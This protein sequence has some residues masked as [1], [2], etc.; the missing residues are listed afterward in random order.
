MICDVYNP[1]LFRFNNIFILFNY[2]C[3]FSG[4]CIF[5]ASLFKSS[6][7]RFS[8]M[9]IDSNNCFFISSFDR[10]FFFLLSAT[11]FHIYK[12]KKNRYSTKSEKK[13]LSKLIFLLLNL[14]KKTPPLQSSFLFI[15]F[16]QSIFNKLQSLRKSTFN[17][18][19]NSYRNFQSFFVHFNNTRVFFN[20]SLQCT[21]DVLENIQT[22]LY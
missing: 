22:V 20:F 19:Q 1:F 15:F 8:S 13:C 16:S 14:Q 9:I 3:C 2:F 10:R 18:I 17:S 4:S 7:S 21:I 5:S 6:N 12:Q 11:P